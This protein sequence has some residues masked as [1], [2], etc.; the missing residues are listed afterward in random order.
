MVGI[1]SV[2][3][4]GGLLY[5]FFDSGNI[6][7][8]AI[9]EMNLV[10]TVSSWA[11]VLEIVLNSHLSTAVFCRDKEIVTSPSK[12]QHIGCNAIGKAD[13]VFASGRVVVIIDRILTE[14]FAEDISVRT[15]AALQVII[16]GTADQSVVAVITI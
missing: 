1:Q 2:R 3:T 16:A 9:I 10:D 14:A 15:A 5:Q 8:F 11:I 12:I 4:V 6:Q 13:D 7:Y